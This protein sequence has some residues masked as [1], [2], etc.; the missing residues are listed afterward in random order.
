LPGLGQTIERPIKVS[1]EQTVDLGTHIVEMRLIQIVLAI[2]L[3]ATVASAD[4]TYFAQTKISEA[5]PTIPYQRA[6]LKFDG[7]EQTMLIE[8]TLDG[9]VGTYGWVV[10]LPTKPTFLKP[11]NPTYISSSFDQVK[12]RIQSDGD[13][14]LIP[15]L[16][17]LCYSAIVLTSGFRHRDSTIG[18]RVLLFAAEGLVPLV[19][20]AFFW[21]VYAQ[22]KGR[23]LEVAADAATGKSAGGVIVDHY[24]T[25]GSYQVSVVSGESGKPILDWLKQRDLSV[26]TDA[27]PVIEQYVKE[28]WC[29]MAAEVRKKEHGAYPPHPI[30]AVFPSEKLIYP[31]RLTGVQSEPLRLELL[32]V[33]DDEATIDGM[34]KWASDNS[35]IEVQV[36][37]TSNDDKE[38]YT[39]WES[40]RYAM[41]KRGNAWTYLRS[42][43]G[44]S[45]MDKD[46]KV[47]FKQLERFQA[48]VMSANGV[49]NRAAG[50]FALALTAIALVIGFVM[51]CLAQP[52]VASLVIGSALAF[53]LAT[54]YAGYSMSDVRIVEIAGSDAYLSRS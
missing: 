25:I 46:F 47:E 4:G 21:P 5:H 54:G 26:G 48:Q 31:M 34:E 53:L 7:K 40:G 35:P 51:C 50:N 2:L 18:M 3:L 16:L 17:A 44:P 13:F 43:V 28:G 22:S 52:Q 14:P 30:K 20:A 27:L 11:V 10:P 39:D 36:A 23:A 19:L 41:A 33:A 37:M 42:D 38:L 49:A 15:L 1:D 32:I 8:S 45:L 6:V 12:P 24:G 29:F 9:P